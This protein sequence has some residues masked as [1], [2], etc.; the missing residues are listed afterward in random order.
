MN[1][2]TLPIAEDAISPKYVVIFADLT[3]DVQP[4]TESVILDMQKADL[5]KTDREYANSSFWVK[6]DESDYL[7]REDGKRVY[8]YEKLANDCARKYLETIKLDV[9]KF[10]GIHIIHDLV[11]DRSRPLEFENKSIKYFVD[12]KKTPR[13]YEQA[14]SIPTYFINYQT[15]TPKP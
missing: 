15:F 13:V 3:D 9:R 4:S 12:P 1:A 14:R 11:D 6:L 7:K 5:K 10:A 8:D 2:G